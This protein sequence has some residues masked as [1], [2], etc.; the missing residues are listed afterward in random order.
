MQT[1]N[2]LYFILENKLFEP[3]QYLKLSSISSKNLSAGQKAIFHHLEVEEDISVVDQNQESK[4]TKEY[5][6]TEHHL[7]YYELQDKKNYYLSQY[8]YTA[9]FIDQLG[10]EY[11]LHV[12]FDENDELL[13]LRLDRKDKLTDKYSQQERLSEQL[14]SNFEQMAVNNSFYVL[15]DLRQQQD[16]L[17]HHLEKQYGE[18]E[19]KLRL[20]NSHVD[21]NAVAYQSVLQEMVQ[22]LEKLSPLRS[23][24]RSLYYLF[25][26]R[27]KQ[28]SLQLQPQNQLRHLEVTEIEESKTPK[29]E[30]IAE[31]NE[32]T[33]QSKNSL[34]FHQS[35]KKAQNAQRLFLDAYN[36]ASTNKFPESFFGNLTEL[37]LEC[38]NQRSDLFFLMES[39]SF[40]PNLEELRAVHELVAAHKKEANNFIFR[41]L[42]SHS[43]EFA[44]RLSDLIQENM[45][46]F[47]LKNSK[48]ELL[49][50]LF[51]M[52]VDFPINTFLIENKPPLLYCISAHSE[53]KPKVDCF[54]VLVEK[55]A[56]LFICMPDGLPL[57]HHILIDPTHPFRQALINNSEKTF[58]NPNFYFKLSS[59]LENWLE[60][61]PGHP[62][63]EEVRACA[64]QYITEIISLRSLS[65]GSISSMQIRQ[66]EQSVTNIRKK[67]TQEQ[68]NAIL[69]DPEISVKREI[70][71]I[72]LAGFMSRLSPNEKRIFERNGNSFVK[73]V[74]EFISENST[75]ACVDLKSATIKCLDDSIKILDLRCQLLDL[76]R[77]VKGRLFKN[78]REANQYNREVKKLQEQLKLLEEPYRS[79]ESSMNSLNQDIQEFQQIISAA[80]TAFFQTLSS[81]GL[82]EADLNDV[83]NNLN[84][85]RCSPS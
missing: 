76:Q 4:E 17:I 18:L 38:E 19:K 56:S 28:A 64:N 6:L 42:I 55:G 36:L 15:A 2:P 35:I 49:E 14:Q 60:K 1:I 77:S 13:N 41:M 51:L 44:T 69:N 65:G 46:P 82:D 33:V 70:Q 23:E 10:Q 34:D 72:M 73:D 40:I 22:L 58:A 43:F 83:L 45:I 25:S 50:F 21:I 84:E 27:V 85:S 20:L 59:A 26:A 11:R 67:L 68:I 8:H 74:E 37:L 81:A 48:A 16:K 66:S 32:N 31:I 62:Q 29:T 75:L 71:H 24:Y 9:Y 79:L 12:Y 63:Q 61:N 7:S 53:A 52:K 30:S 78:R 47:A 54:S 80:P 57:A 39:E 5:I 3:N